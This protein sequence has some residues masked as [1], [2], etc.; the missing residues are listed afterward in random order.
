MLVGDLT[1]S[2]KKKHS[3]LVQVGRV[4]I[5]GGIKNI[6]SKNFCCDNSLYSI[7][8]YRS[9]VALITFNARKEYLNGTNHTFNYGSYQD[10]KQNIDDIFLETND[11]KHLESRFSEEMH[12]FNY[13][14]PF[15]TIDFDGVQL[16]IEDFIYQIRNGNHS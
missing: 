12:V 3:E 1:E 16:Q 13:I 7:K 10:E 4:Q 14:K 6:V 9:K 15:Q 8:N 11:E 5:I 2:E